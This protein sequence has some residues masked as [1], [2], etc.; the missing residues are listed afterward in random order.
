MRVSGKL[1]AIKWTTKRPKGPVMNV[2]KKGNK[3]KISPNR[4]EKR[5]SCENNKGIRK[6]LLHHIK[7]IKNKSLI[8]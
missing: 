7:C 8:P 3:T 2:L 6:A 5:G 1:Q 4:R